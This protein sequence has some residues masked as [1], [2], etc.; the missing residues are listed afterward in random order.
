[1]IT[2]LNEALQQLAGPGVGVAVQDVSAPSAPLW[3]RERL[4]M[5]R[6]V[7][8]RI[9]EFTAGRA[10]ARQ[11]MQA[12]G[13]PEAAIAM[14]ADRAPVWPAGVVGSISHAGGMGAALVARVGAIAGIGLDLELNEPLPPDLWPEVC[15]SAELIALTKLPA[16]AQGQTARLI[17]SA[18]ECCYKCIYPHTKA[19]LSFGAM[20]IR[21]DLTGNTYAATLVEPAGPFAPGTTWVGGFARIGGLIATVMV[22]R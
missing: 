14:G 2:A 7:P 15:T 12:L 21:P 19:V 9:A 17:F 13:L 6:A 8:S 20:E 4:A 3:A 10:A 5:V 22:S 16:A 18:K 11:A 1:M